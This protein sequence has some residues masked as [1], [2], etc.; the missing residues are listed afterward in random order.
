[1]KFP[2]WLSIGISILAMQG[3]LTLPKTVT[4]IQPSTAQNNPRTTETKLKTYLV[5]KE[6]SISYPSN[7][8]VERTQNPPG[9]TPRELLIITNQKLPKRGGD[10][11]P[12]NIIKTDIQIERGAF[13]KV[14]AQTFRSASGSGSRL[15]QR[16]KL[17]VGG[18]EAVRLWISEPEAETIIMLV[19]YNKNETLY[20]AS[21]YARSNPSAINIIQ[22]IHGSVR[23]VE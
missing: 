14:V 1:M 7:W 5:P 17:T 2:L 16:G 22:R 23:V 21:F 3:T 11:L 15:T 12:P 20:L 4:G 10:G 18:R 8:L 6:F 9:T 13:E 19:R